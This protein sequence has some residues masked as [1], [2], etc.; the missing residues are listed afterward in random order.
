[1]LENRSRN[2]DRVARQALEHGARGGWIRCE[3]IGQRRTRCKIGGVDEPQHKLG[4]IPFIL[5]RVRWTLQIEVGE[6]TQ[7]CRTHVDL[8]A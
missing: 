6:H 8:V 4:I 1:M 2:F 7:Q 3:P 5:G